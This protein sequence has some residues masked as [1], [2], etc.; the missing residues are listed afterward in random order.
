MEK[1]DFA[2]R[3]V[4]VNSQPIDNEVYMQY[5]R[6]CPSLDA[7][8]E[9]DLKTIRFL[10][11]ATEEEWR[12]SEEHSPKWKRKGRAKITQTDRFGHNALHVASYRGHNDIV[13]A[14]LSPS[15]QFNVGQG[16]G[17]WLVWVR[18][19]EGAGRD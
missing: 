1:K 18:G 8:W 13:E 10:L 7:A 12:K 14:L 5:M 4:Y 11:T 2:D 16:G 17:E 3:S 9:G 15:I 6:G 19:G